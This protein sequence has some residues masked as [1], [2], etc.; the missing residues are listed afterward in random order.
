MSEEIRRI[1]QINPE[2]AQA[3][4]EAYMSPD[5]GYFMGGYIAGSVHLLVRSAF[6]I[7]R[8]FADA[9]FLGVVL[10]QFVHW[11]QYSRTEDGWVVKSIVVSDHST[12]TSDILYPLTGS[13]TPWLSVL[14]FRYSKSTVT[15]TSVMCTDQLVWQFGSFTCLSMVSVA[16]SSSWRS[17]VS[18]PLASLSVMIV[19]I[20]RDVMVVLGRRYY[21]CT[22]PGQSLS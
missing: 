20:I 3:A 16:T 4:L 8:F 17:D 14:V 1:I 22:C 2:A 7:D 6:L 12:I 9:I 10:H 19:L 11:W 15:S 21:T 5:K 13:T 18:S